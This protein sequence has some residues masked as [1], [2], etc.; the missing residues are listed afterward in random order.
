MKKTLGGGIILVLALIIP[1]RA[2][3]FGYPAA[4][5][6][7]Y[8]IKT[9]FTNTTAVGK[10][11][12]TIKNVYVEETVSSRSQRPRSIRII[13]LYNNGDIS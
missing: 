6:A 13:G 3:E 7:W 8:F 12:W 9:G 5:E 2:E 10:G 4:G 1:T 11:L